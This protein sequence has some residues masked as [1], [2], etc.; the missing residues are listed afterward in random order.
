M[1]RHVSCVPIAIHNFQF[2]INSLKT[3]TKNKTLK[4]NPSAKNSVIIIDYLDYNIDY[5][6]PQRCDETK[7]YTA[8]IPF[9]NKYTVPMVS[10]VQ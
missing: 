10:P 2:L 1:C 8:V 7:V 3:T 6:E 5:L 4:L 9:Y